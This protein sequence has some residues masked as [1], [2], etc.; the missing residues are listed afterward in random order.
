MPSMCAE[1]LDR[2]SLHAAGTVSLYRD[3]RTR[4][5]RRV[6]ESTENCRYWSVP[7]LRWHQG[8]MLERAGTKTFSPLEVPL[9]VESLQ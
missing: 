5:A 4:S 7:W 1:V 8:H 6:S 3:C 2:T 9:A